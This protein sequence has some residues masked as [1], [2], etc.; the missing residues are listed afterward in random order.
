MP[1][2]APDFSEKDLLAINRV[3]FGNYTLPAGRLGSPLLAKNH[4]EISGLCPASAPVHG[5]FRPDQMPWSTV[6][7]AG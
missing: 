2:T 3:L 6:T 1:K 5:K 4:P 7:W